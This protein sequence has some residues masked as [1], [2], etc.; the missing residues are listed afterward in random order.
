MGKAFSFDDSVDPSGDLVWCIN[1]QPENAWYREVFDL[2]IETRCRFAGQSL[3]METVTKL[4]DQLANNCEQEI[5]RNRRELL[6]GL[7]SGDPERRLQISRTLHQGG[8]G[9][10]LDEVLEELN[11]ESDWIPPAQGTAEGLFVVLRIFDVDDPP[12][13]IYKRYLSSDMDISP[14]SMMAAFVLNRLNDVLW[15]QAHDVLDIDQNNLR[16]ALEGLRYLGMLQEEEGKQSL[17]AD[18]GAPASNGLGRLGGIGRSQKYLVI[19]KEARRLATEMLPDSGQWKSRQQAV[20]TIL[21][22]VLEFARKNNTIY[23]D[24]QAESTIYGYLKP[25]PDSMFASKNRSPA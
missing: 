22:S 6:D 17:F 2:Y 20:R 12:R 24:M 10:S 19:A 18:A 15:A 7:R 1:V 4:S 21:P 23:S 3:S 9:L 16:Q 13:P 5:S 8:V 14:V 25:L 11:D